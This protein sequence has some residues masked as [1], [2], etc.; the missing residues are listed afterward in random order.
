MDGL[1]QVVHLPLD[2]KAEKSL[3]FLLAESTRSYSG[4]S[5]RIVLF[6]LQG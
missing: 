4:V 3:L 1:L 6:I 2:M 5:A